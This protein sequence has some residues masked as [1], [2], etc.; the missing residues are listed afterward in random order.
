MRQALQTNDVHRHLLYGHC[1][2]WGDSRYA[3][4]Y[5]CMYVCI[6]TYM[7][8]CGLCVGTCI[9]IPTYVSVRP[10]FVNLQAKVCLCRIPS[11]MSCNESE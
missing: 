1:L 9:N 5:V 3:S 8:V 6:H 10:V 11:K 4:I 7:S 2:V